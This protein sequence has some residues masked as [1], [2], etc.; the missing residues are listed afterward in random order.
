M[1]RIVD[2][3]RP[4]FPGRICLMC[5]E[6]LVALWGPPE[7]LRGHPMGSLVACTL[8]EEG[9]VVALEP[10]GGPRPGGGDE[11]GD[12]LRGRLPGAPVSRMTYLKLRHAVLR[13]IRSYFEEQ[14]FLEVD[15]P[16]LVRAPSPEPQFSPVEAEGGF[17]IASPE[18]QMKRML[19]GGF[20]KIFRIGAVFRAGES[21]A[22]HNPEFTLLEWYRAYRGLDAM[23]EDLEAL[24]GL[25]A[26]LSVPA[27]DTAVPAVDA[28]VSTANAAAPLPGNP[29][30]ARTF[31]ARTFAAR[32]LGARPFP[33][34]S[35][36]ELFQRHLGMTVAGVT[37]APDLR[38]AALAAKV[39]GA[40]K[41]PGDF[42]QA[43][44]VLW[45]R[46]EPLLGREPLLVVDWPAPLASL[47]RLNPAD[48][49]VAERMELYAGGLELANGFAELTDPAEQRRRFE[50]QL[51]ARKRQ[52]LP[53][54]PLDEK[55]LAALAQ[56]M[57]P[58]SGMALGVDRLVMLLGGAAD[59]RQVL[60]FSA[61]EC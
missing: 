27:A 1:G 37:T 28:A 26:P 15:T 30:S 20:E 47:A 6:R 59:I 25:L 22:H 2:L 12:A 56:G 39:A 32:S 41:L 42:E 5:E 29:H 24:L 34:I 36:A 46:V 9:E 21:G 33:R 54:V 8:G 3:P 53:P 11:S 23:G 17:L 61:E 35:I 50:R 10:L 48:P 19:V 4:E 45:E 52:G 57:P 49:N 18:F 16:V 38:A 14:G 31:A 7:L 40:E 55:F 13:T 43:F 58:A 51:N 60:P 44:S